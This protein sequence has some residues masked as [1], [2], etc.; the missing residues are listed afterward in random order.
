MVI[1]TCDLFYFSVSELREVWMNDLNGILDFSHLDVVLQF[2]VIDFTQ[3]RIDLRILE[4]HLQ[5][6]SLIRSFIILFF[7]LLFGCWFLLLLCVLLFLE[8]L[9]L[10]LGDEGL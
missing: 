9:G 2:S 6:L 7:Q 5:L 10:D 8:F 1:A 4:V 3:N